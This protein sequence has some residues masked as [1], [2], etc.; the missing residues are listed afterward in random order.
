MIYKAFQ[1]L[2]LSTLGM[3]A[4]RLPKTGVGE[5]I[6]EVKAAKL[7]NTPITTA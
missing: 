3:G 4:M 6:D 7:L 2:Q 5:K 1:K